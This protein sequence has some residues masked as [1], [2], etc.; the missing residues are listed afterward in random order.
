MKKKLKILTA[1]FITINIIAI[2]IA[3]YSGYSLQMLCEMGCCGADLV[4]AIILSM[5]WAL[6]SRTQNC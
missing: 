1:I 3:I 2:I 5:F 4:I 6:S